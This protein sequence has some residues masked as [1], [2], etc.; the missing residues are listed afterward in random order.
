MSKSLGNIVDPFYLIKKFGTDAVRYFFLKEIPAYED[1][2]L[3]IE[4]FRNTYNADLAN[5]LG[6]LISRVAKLCEKADFSLPNSNFKPQITDLRKVSQCNKVI[7]ETKPWELLKCRN[8]PSS[9]PKTE[10]VLEKLVREILEI[11]CLL[12]PFMPQTSQKIKKQFTGRIKAREPLFP[13][14]R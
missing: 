2:D 7:D 13:R 1:G 3:T 14:V 8:Y 11:A 4:R 5:G 9:Y 10:K 6:N 12:E